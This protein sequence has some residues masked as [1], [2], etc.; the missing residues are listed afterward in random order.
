MKF[1]DILRY[2]KRP[3]YHVNVDLD[4]IE[5]WI[6]DNISELD[7]QM[8]PDFQ[9]GHVWTKEQQIAYIEYLLRGGQSGRDFYFNRVGGMHDLRDPKSHFV[10]VDGLQR[11][12]A[13]FAF[14]HNEIP[15]FGYYLKEFE[16]RL[17]MANVMFSMNV[18]DLSNKK[19]VLIWY[20]EMNSGG[21]PHK[22]EEL[23]KVKK[24]LE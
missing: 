19:D 7:L 17:R 12:T 20:L 5:D 21:T 11:I 24:M 15:V 14:I 23:E 13:I 3:G 4:Y 1:S 8:N 10:C 22:P 18:N 2:T 16:D 6:E 9:R